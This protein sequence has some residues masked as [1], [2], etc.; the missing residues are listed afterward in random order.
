MKRE[1]RF[2]C[3]QA[4]LVY[5]PRVV[6]LSMEGGLMKFLVKS[7]GLKICE[8]DY[9]VGIIVEKIFFVG[10]FLRRYFF[11]DIFTCVG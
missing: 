9:F 2:F 3:D 8:N 5:I 11:W 10:I 7:Y 6:W 4:L 1:N